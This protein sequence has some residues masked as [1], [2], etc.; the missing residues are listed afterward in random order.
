[1]NDKRKYIVR[2]FIL[3]VAIVFLSR[4][5]YLQ[6]LN[7]DLKAKAQSK[8]VKSITT[9]PAR[10]VIFERNGKEVIAGNKL[11]Y[12][13]TVVVK[14]AKKNPIQDTAKFYRLLGTTAEEYLKVYYTKTND[15]LTRDYSPIIPMSLIEISPQRHA[16]IIDKFHY[17][18]FGFTSR[19]VRDYKYPILANAFGYLSKVDKQDMIRDEQGY[20][21]EQDTIGKI[22]L[23][24]N[25]EKALRG[26]KG[27]R[28][29]IKNARGIIKKSFMEGAQD[30]N[31]V[32]G[33]SLIS[34]IDLDLQLLGEKLMKG[35][36]GSIVAIDPK[37]GEILT[38][39]SSPSY[40]PNDLVVNKNFSKNYSALRNDST[41]PLFDRAT[42]TRYPP[43]STFK[44]LCALI[45]LQ[46]GVI[47]PTNLIYTGSCPNVGDHAAIGYYNV[48]RAIQS[49][50]NCYFIQLFKRTVQQG[51]K[52]HWHD[53]AK[54]GL[55]KWRQH[56]VSF[57]LGSTL[58]SDI[59]Q[60]NGGF[61]PDTNTY[62]RKWPG[63]KWNSET[64]RS[65]GIG[66]GEMGLTP[67]QMA[68][69]TVAIANKGYYI[70][71]HLIKAI[72][73]PKGEYDRLEYKKH[74][75]TIDSIHF[76][77]VIDGMEAVVLNGTARLAQIPG[78]A[79]CG[80]TGTAENPHGDDHSLFVAF[81]PKDDPKI[82]VAVIVENSGYGSTWAAPIASLLIERHLTGE[83]KRENLVK[84]VLKYKNK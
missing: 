15:S 67:L 35:K 43:G 8:T 83:V 58:G 31:A 76:Q 29:V 64:I 27:V 47:S 14:D 12:D 19:T 28:K 10:G 39:V 56:V 79:V 50:S 71:P 4:L 74:V 42:M 62:Q 36:K 48:G 6:V 82:A 78:I 24:R 81:A 70:T 7:D 65:L 61:V 20:Y 38:I 9:Y 49:S 16:S 68:N 34:S 22:G 37:T 21:V 73:T 59:S 30:T 17:S 60:E 13:L 66:Q 18:G 2:G 77:P 46:E 45:G 33:Y 84:H 55:M 51:K 75:T 52:E 57:G 41:I 72:V 11:V 25:Y 53:D 69:M 23:E 44:P 26:Q 3:V 1:M 54:Y 40:D 80:K 63:F 32:A 5:F